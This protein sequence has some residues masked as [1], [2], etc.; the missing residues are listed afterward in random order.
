MTG[1]PETPDIETSSA[2]YAARFSGPVGTWLLAVQER[3]TLQS[4]QGMPGARVLDVGGGHGQITG[5]LIREG[6]DVTVVGSA[7]VCAARISS[8]VESRQ[9]RFEVGNVLDLPF[10][11]QSFDIVIS[12]R[13]VPHISQWQRLLQELARVAKRMVI[14]DY[15]DLRSLNALTP[16]LFSFKRR[17]E[18]NT[19]EYLSFH[20]RD[21]LRVFDASGFEKAQRYPE[22]F[23]PMVLHRTLKSPSLSAPLETVCRYLGLTY[24]FGSPVILKVV[25]KQ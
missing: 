4:L 15:P 12:Y 11:D 10:K 16:L 1:F 7:P 6:F 22:F 14:I 23:L 20:Q 5:P 25:R 21:L 3:A 17:I 24:L 2:D 18:K 19:R 13:L 9:C 8:F